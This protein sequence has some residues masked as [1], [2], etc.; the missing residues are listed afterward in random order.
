MLSPHWC[1]IARFGAFSFCLFILQPSKRKNVGVIL[2]SRAASL[3]PRGTPGEQVV[4]AAFSLLLRG[5]ITAVLNITKSYFLQ[6][7]KRI[8]KSEHWPLPLCFLQQHDLP[9]EAPRSTLAPVNELLS[10]VKLCNCQ[11]WALFKWC[12]HFP[13]PHFHPPLCLCP[14][15]G[16]PHFLFLFLH[17]APIKLE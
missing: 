7:G 3:I 4:S 5:L 14:P 16:L 8:E 17:Q 13:L 9:S 2:A 10:H 1:N 12:L 15:L 6:P 11:I